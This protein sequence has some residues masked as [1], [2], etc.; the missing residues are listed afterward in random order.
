MNEKNRSKRINNKGLTIYE[1][2]IIVLVIGFLIFLYFPR[3]NINRV[4]GH[5]VK[6]HSN[7]KY[8]GLA[9][10]MYV[11][12]NL[13]SYPTPDKWCDMITPYLGRMDEEVFQCPAAIIKALNGKDTEKV[14][15]HYAM[16]PNCEPNSPPDTILLFE[17]KGGW[18]LSGGPE[19]LTTENHTSN[20]CNVLFNDG[21][22]G[23]I[24]KDEIPNLKWNAEEKRN[25]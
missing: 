11:T 24:R 9:F 21:S 14:R 16:N 5:N 12:D 18:N 1:V 8:F 23:T 13:N 10:Q 7:L 3:L 2:I 25:D 4:P 15:C 22:V 20:T 17:T 6:C 19:L